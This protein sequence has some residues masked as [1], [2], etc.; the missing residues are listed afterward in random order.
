MAVTSSEAE[1]LEKPGSPRV[2][3]PTGEAGEAV[4]LSLTTG[5]RVVHPQSSVAALRTRVLSPSTA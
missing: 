4:W 3:W 1:P 5:E 2:H